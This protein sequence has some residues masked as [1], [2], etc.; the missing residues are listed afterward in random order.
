MSE[1]LVGVVRET[2]QPEHVSLWLRPPSAQGEAGSRRS[3]ARV[4]SS[5]WFLYAA[6]NALGLAEPSLLSDSRASEGT[7]L[8]SPATTYYILYLMHFLLLRPIRASANDV[9]CDQ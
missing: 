3:A 4:A 5:W 6:F 2:M 8:P 9:R 1:D 7:K